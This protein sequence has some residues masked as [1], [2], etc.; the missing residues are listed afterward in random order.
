MSFTTCDQSWRLLLLD[1][2]D[3]RAGIMGRIKVFNLELYLHF[4]EIFDMI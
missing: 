3:V 2:T 1:R 4:S